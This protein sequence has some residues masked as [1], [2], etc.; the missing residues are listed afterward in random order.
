MSSLGARTD[1]R[2]IPATRR[3]AWLAV[4][5]MVA[6][7][8]LGPGAAGVAATRETGNN[9][10]VKIHD[11]AGEPHPEV[12]NQPHVCTFHMHFFFADAGQT[13]SWEIQKWAPGPKGQ[14]VLSGTYHTDSHGQDRQPETGAYSLPNG[15]YKLFW[16]GDTGKH[17]KMKV[18]WVKCATSQPTPTP[19]PGGGG[20]G[21]TPT[22]TPREECEDQGKHDDEDCDNG[23]TPTP[24]PTP[25]GGGGGTPTP[26]PTPGGGGGG[27]TPTPT[28]GGGDGGAQGTPTPTPVGGA[29][30]G[31]TGTPNVTLPPTD[32]S[33]GQAGPI[34]DG[35]RTV[36]LVVAAMIATILLL[37][38]VRMPARRLI[39]RR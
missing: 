18:F 28:P 22:P 2:G 16:D 21:A 4:F 5:M 17:D 7:A 36:L 14:V 9:G 15:H 13:G 12:R 39:H 25:G 3:L 1:R 30:G 6:V 8:V 38:P 20:G 33:S 19:T 34:G 10:T 23:A 11:G 29:V 31:V 37:T 27:A 35:W 32:T 26:T 24:T